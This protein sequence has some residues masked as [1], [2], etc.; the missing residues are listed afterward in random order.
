MNNMGAPLIGQNWQD[1]L[2]KNDPPGFGPPI[3]EAAIQTVESFVVVPCASGGV[4]V[5]V[6]RDGFDI[7]ICVDGGGVIE[8]VLVCRG[9]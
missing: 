7:E 4:Q 6:H 1:Q 5:E 2:R 8:S 9:N 3:S